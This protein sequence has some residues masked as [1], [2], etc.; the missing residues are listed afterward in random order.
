MKFL[1][2]LI[3]TFAFV[4]PLAFG[5]VSS[6]QI[7]FF[8][9]SNTLVGTGTYSFDTI[10]EET[11]TPFNDLAGLDWFFNLPDYGISISASEGDSTSRESLDDEGVYLTTINLSETLRFYDS[12]GSFISHNDESATLRTSVR[13]LEFSNSVQYI[14]DDVTVGTGTYV[15]TLIPE[16]TA[17]ALAATM[18]IAGLIRRHR[19]Q[20][21]KP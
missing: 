5:A 20:P 2:T 14:V 3:V 15:A 17:P 7:T 8:D 9:A 19:R 6:F 1:A 4:R 11:Y 21:T 18:A 16:P 10:P 13:F 12:A